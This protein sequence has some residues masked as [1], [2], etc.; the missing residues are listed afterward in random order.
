[1]VHRDV[2]LE[3][4]VLKEK[5]RFDV[6]VT[7]FGFSSF[8]NENDPLTLKIGSPI[9]KAP[10]LLNEGAKISSKVDI[11]AV[12]VMTYSLLAGYEK[13]PFTTKHEVLETDV[14]FPCGMFRGISKEAKHFI[15]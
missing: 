2:K 10:E 14:K 8:Y 13:F 11:W 1:M 7:D 6:K 12:G 5:G 4:I 15:Q 3:N 9:Y